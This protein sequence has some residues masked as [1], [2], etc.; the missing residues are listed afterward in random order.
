MYIIVQEK[1][2]DEELMGMVH[3][4]VVSGVSSTAW[5]TAVGWVVYTITQNKI[6][7]RGAYGVVT[8][9]YLKWWL[10]HGMLHGRV[11]GGVR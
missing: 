5:Y 9:P 4:R 2:L 7:G 11:G 3:G 10:G 1:H 6:L 8:R